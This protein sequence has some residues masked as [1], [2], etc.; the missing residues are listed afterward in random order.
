MR[1]V[2]AKIAG[3]VQGVSFRKFL[4]DEADKI[5]IKGHVRN[6]DSGEVEVIAEGSP[7]EVEK[8]IGVCKKGNQF[9]SVKGVDLQD[10]N[11]IGFDDFKIL[12]I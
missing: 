7:E 1:T 6:L 11:H 3:Q 2:R 12:N 10:M 5:G 4:K 9:T 8:M